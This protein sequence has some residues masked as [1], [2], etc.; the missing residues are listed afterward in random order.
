[1]MLGPRVHER[2][3]NCGWYGAYNTAGY[4][5]K[6]L[7]SHSCAT[8]WTPR[9]CT[10]HTRHQHGTKASYSHCACRCWP[11]RLATLE[12]ED[13]CRRLR[14]YGRGRLVDA[15]FARRRL[16]DLRDQGL[17]RHRISELS[18]VDESI[19]LR[20]VVGKIRRG[21]RELTRRITRETEAAILA[22]TVDPADGG[23][24]VDIG[25]TRRR[26]RSLVALGWYPSLLAREAGMNQ[27]QLD[28]L[29]G[30]A[31]RRVRPGT[32]R[33][34]HALYRDLALRPSPTGVYADRARARARSAGWPRP[35]IVGGRV[36]AGL[37]LEVDLAGKAVA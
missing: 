24:P 13:Q 20:I 26:L 21:R 32:A 17:G 2:S 37:P 1:M 11:C 30:G 6:A 29:L 25:P 15:G 7:R 16:I 4:A 33:R 35:T 34:V 18:G 5:D 23:L 28:R 31:M 19:L 10:H 9:V 22:V 12:H 14:A 27:A 36:L 3:C 8:D